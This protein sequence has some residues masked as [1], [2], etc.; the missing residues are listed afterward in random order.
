MSFGFAAVGN[1]SQRSGILNAA[2]SRL[3]Q[4]KR[5]GRNCIVSGV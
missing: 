2:D 4:A 5:A 3:Y 1:E